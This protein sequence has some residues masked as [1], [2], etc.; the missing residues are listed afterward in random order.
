MVVFNLRVSFADIV[1]TNY[2]ILN[3]FLKVLAHVL[4]VYGWIHTSSAK[5][6]AAT[7]KTGT[8]GVA[9]GIRLKYLI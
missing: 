9:T 6:N 1:V 2:S 5:S 4:S 8:V 3:T 7:F